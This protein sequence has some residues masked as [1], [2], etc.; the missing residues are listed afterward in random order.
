MA[1]ATTLTLATF[2]IIT[3]LDRQMDQWLETHSYEVRPKHEPTELTDQENIDLD[4][5]KF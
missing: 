3:Q 1:L 4:Q 5:I 2:G